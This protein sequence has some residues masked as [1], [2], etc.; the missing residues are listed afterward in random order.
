MEFQLPA[1]AN[2]L[3]GRRFGRLVAESAGRNERGYLVWRCCCDCGQTVDV[4]PA[5]LTS[6]NTT[7]CGCYRREVYT[8]TSAKPTNRHELLEDETVAR[9]TL[10]RADGT[11]RGYALVDAADLEAVSRYRWSMSGSGVKHYV[12]A[13][14]RETRRQLLLGRYLLKL[15]D[16]E[17]VRYKNG[18]SLDNRRGNLAVVRRG[19]NDY[20]MIDHGA[21]VRLALTNVSGEVVAYTI[22]DVGDFGLA[23]SRRWGLSD[24]GY[25]VHRSNGRSVWLHKLLLGDAAQGREGDH[26]DGD[27]LNNRRSNLRPATVQEN[28]YNKKARSRSG[29][30]GVYLC[31]NSARWMAQ[32]TVEKKTYHLG[33]FSTPADAARAYNEAAVKHH[34]EFA[35]LNKIPDVPSLV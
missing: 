19:Q 31:S 21:A 14:E 33:C 3:T 13:H 15:G 16:A 6:K 18:D 12:T 20:E 24:R 28:A 8:T 11:V 17:D 29:Y 1:R 9:L 26:K 32:I 30:K 7:S 27:R 35:C 2:N 34:G 22:I 4:Q 5:R 23:L 25:A 10:E